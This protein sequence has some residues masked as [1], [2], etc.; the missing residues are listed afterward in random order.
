[1][2]AKTV[3]E[4]LTEVECKVAENAQGIDGLRE[5]VVAGFRAMDRRF[6]AV[7]QRFEAIDR[8]FESMEQRFD[9]RFQSMEQRLDRRFEVVDQKMGRQFLWMVGIQITTMLAVVG[10][11]AGIAAVA[12]GR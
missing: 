10:A 5:A 2:A 11:M 1:M 9:Q 4:R 12:L 6:E 8:R 3:E 7:D